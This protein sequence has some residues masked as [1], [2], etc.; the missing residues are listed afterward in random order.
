METVRNLRDAEHVF[1]TQS[2]LIK[3][4]VNENIEKYGL[5]VCLKSGSVAIP[6]SLKLKLSNFQM[7]TWVARKK[8]KK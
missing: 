8:N 5:N 3:F 7:L 1:V 4:S 6:V 2:T